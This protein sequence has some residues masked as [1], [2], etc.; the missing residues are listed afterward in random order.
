MSELFEHATEERDVIRILNSILEH[1]LA[2]AVRYTQHSLMVFGIDRAPLVAW[3][4]AQADESLLHAQQVGEMIVDLGGEVS[5]GIG[6]LLDATPR[7]A[8]DILRE[9]LVH[10]TAAVAGYRS[11]L[12][13]VEGRSVVLE[14]FARQMVANEVKHTAEVRK[15]LREPLG[16]D[17][18]ATDAAAYPVAAWGH[19]AAHPFEGFQQ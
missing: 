10:E 18:E 15:M 3:L 1:E 8:T 5:L 7:T 9:S 19:R 11:L 4:R 17:G 14:E 6:P 12:H 2:G 16:H 13:L